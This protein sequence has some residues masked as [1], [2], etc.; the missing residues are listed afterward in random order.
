MEEIALGNNPR[1]EDYILL[2]RLPDFF[3][4]P[5]T[6]Q[7]HDL[8]VALKVDGVHSVQEVTFTLQA[9]LL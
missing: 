6:L 2:K 9:L 7:V 5:C 3:F 1:S 8:H 4:T